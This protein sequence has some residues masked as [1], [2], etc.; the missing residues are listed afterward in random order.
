MFVLCCFGLLGAVHLYFELI[1]SS[2]CCV[3]SFYLIYCVITLL[4]D[5]FRLFEFFKM[6]RFLLLFYVVQVVLGCYGLFKLR[7]VVQVAFY[8]ELS[9][10]GWCM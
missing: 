10:C 9:E 3:R 4:L 6:C 5:F 1:F 7:K 2:E 8:G